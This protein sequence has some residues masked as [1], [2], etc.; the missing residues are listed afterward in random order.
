MNPTAIR[1]A[2]SIAI[3]ALV[4]L[5]FPGALLGQQT[6][7]GQG[8]SS[9]GAPLPLIANRM[10]ESAEIELDGRLDD[11]A[12]TA[13]TPITDFTQQEPVEGG[14]PT[15]RTEIRVTYDADNLYI[16][17]MLYDDPSGILA[18]QRERD[19]FLS[20]DDRFMWILDTFRDGRTG[21]F[22]EINAAGMM[23]D[24]VL[25]GGGGGGGFGGG[26]R[27]WDG[28]WETRT[29]ILDNG[30]S[31][32]I[33]IPFRTLNFNPNESSWGINFQR[34]IRRRNEEILWRGWRRSE[35]L[36]SPVFAGEL[37]GLTGMSQ[38]L[39]LEAVTSAIQNW[40]NQ[41]NLESTAAVDENQFPSDVSLDVNYSVTSSLRA[42]VSLNTDFAEVESDQRRVNLTRFPIRLPEQRDFFLEGS[43]VFSFAPR[44]GPTPFFSRQ[45]GLNQG[46]QIPITYGTRLTG[47]AGPFELGF[48]QIGTGEHDY[49]R[50][51]AD[52][53]A[54]EVVPRESFTV[55]RVRRKLFEQSAI[56]A[57]YTRRATW[58]DPRDP[59]IDPIDQHTA[60][61]DLD[62][63]TRSFLGDKNLEM[64]AFVAW[65]SNPLPASDADHVDYSFQD[66]SSHGLRLSYPNDVWTAHISYRQFGDEYDPAV[67]FVNRNNFRRIEPN[68]GWHP[69][70]PGV[71]WLRKLDFSVQF[72]ELV[73]LDDDFP[74]ASAYLLTGLGGV[75]E[76]EW[77]FNLLGMDFESGDNIDLAATRTYEYLD[78]GFNPDRSV[79]PQPT[80]IDPGGY[81]TWNYRVNVRTAGRRRVS[82]FGNLFW[83][84]FWDGDRVGGFGRISFRPSPAVTLSTNVQYNDVT[85]PDGSFTASLYELETDWT[86]SPW[87]AVTSQIQYDDQSELVGL[88]A[89]LRWIV[90][91]GNDVYLVFSQNWR[92]DPDDLLDPRR[93]FVMLSRGASIKANYTYRF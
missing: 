38:G 27:A 8:G 61:V 49:T 91:P 9:G 70:T 30:W 21:Y 14:E 66:L 58:A 31:A 19:A 71:S 78:F 81:T 24:A 82:L 28:I 75:E 12:W 54:S 3:F 57:I 83:G 6:G 68:M 16:G 76:R 73:S 15:E 86:P 93:D 1:A 65:N 51:D 60:G 44:S 50:V 64:E 48:Y 35:G 41:P 4:A 37:T 59:S 80:F 74:G 85:L 11:P 17:A 79:D 29:A 20:T 63:S 52:S 18:F 47:Q 55:A 84:G 42:S 22:F 72:R 10:A 56:G 87:V 34:T 40:R 62:F 53:I 43:G 25:T 77:E 88:F 26:G 23:G 92:Y 69:R 2:V 13:A 7:E 39:G 90:K 32:E 67:G 46:Q 89:R 45:V 5:L 36:R 33:R